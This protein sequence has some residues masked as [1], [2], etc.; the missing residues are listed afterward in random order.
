[1][2]RRAWA[3]ILTLIVGG[4]VLQ[5]PAH[6]GME[7]PDDADADAATDARS[8]IPSDVEPGTKRVDLEVTGMT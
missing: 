2:S 7:M 3:L 1:M 4:V 6:S 5:I 8:D